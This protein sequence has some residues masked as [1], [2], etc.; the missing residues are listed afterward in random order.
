MR[1]YDLAIL[2]VL[3]G[4]VMSIFTPFG[5]PK[6]IKSPTLASQIEL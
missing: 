2:V 1:E 5:A 4:L 3:S 6:P